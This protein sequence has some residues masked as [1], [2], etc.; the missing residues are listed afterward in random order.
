MPKAAVDK[1]NNT[2]GSE[3]QIDANARALNR[4]G[5]MQPISLPKQVKRL[6]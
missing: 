6:T 2:C 4:H 3:Q 1:N 5:S